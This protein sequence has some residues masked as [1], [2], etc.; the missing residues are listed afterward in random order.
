MYGISNSGSFAD[1]K[2]ISVSRTGSGS[3]IAC[4]YLYI[5]A[6][7]GKRPLINEDVYI[8][9]QGFGGHLESSVAI[10]NQVVNSS[11]EMIFSLDNIQYRYAQ[12]IYTANWAALLNVA[13]QIT[14]E[15]ALN[16]SNPE[17]HINEVG[18]AYKCWNPQTGDVT[19]DCHL[20]A[21]PK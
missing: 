17:G 2:Y 20:A 11:T 21:S 14:F 4:G 8:V 15:I 6:G 9:P 18:I 16:T 7:V 5:N 13:N 1:E 10:V 12:T 19:T 3:E